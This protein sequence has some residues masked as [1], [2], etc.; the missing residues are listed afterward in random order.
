[1]GRYTDSIFNAPLSFHIKPVQNGGIFD[2]ILRM[3][4]LRPEIPNTRFA[5]YHDHAEYFT[6]SMHC[7][8]TEISGAQSP[9]PKNPNPE[10]TSPRGK[11]LFFTAT[12]LF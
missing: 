2:V 9:S 4:V 1:L 6:A 3:V 5:Q 10:S 12:V 11:H 7:T 8:V